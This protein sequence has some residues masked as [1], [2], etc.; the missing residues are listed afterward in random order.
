VKYFLGAFVKGSLVLS[1]LLTGLCFY[2]SAA[3][4]ARGHVNVATIQGSINPAS[5][6]YLQRVIEES[7]ND[8]ARA[9]VIQLDTPGGLVSSTKDILQAILNAKVPV[10]VFVSP[11][12]AWAG[13][14]GTFITIAGHVA[15]MTPGS[16]IGAAHPV[17]LGGGGTAPP[18]EQGD[19]EDPVAA[20][21]DL[22]AEKAE[23]LLAAFIASI[24]Q[25]RNR[26]VEWAEKAV[27]ESVAVGSEEALELGVIDLMADDLN[28]LLEK[29]DG[30]EVV[31]DGE[32][33]VLDLASVELVMLEMTRMNRLMNVLASPDVAMIL[34]MVGL[35]GL[36]IEANS[37][38]VGVPGAVGLVCLF[39]G[40]IALQI[41]PFSWMGLVLLLAGIGFFIAEIFVTSFGVLFA[42]GVV[43]FLAGGSMLFSIPEESDLT[44]NF[45]QVLVP[46]VAAVSLFGFVV[47]ASIGKTFATPQIA[48]VE[49]MLGM[50]ALAVT[51]LNPDG[52]VFVHGEN[53]MARASDGPIE[54]GES[55]EITAMD[56]LLLTVRKALPEPA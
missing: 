54:A 17:G 7:E 13:S 9:V 44:V 40:G 38:G 32:T 22:A 16:S 46:A 41:L 39:M 31:V 55:V 26:N 11:R 50:R 52:T 29:I 36:Y 43:C 25:E 33:V 6:A 47:V 42:L 48:G 35:L 20:Q 5:S 37:P 51:V 34:I 49:E 19:E 1:L 28:D 15:A 14:A 30:R 10:I 18:A 45:W 4:A 27:R 53:W 8:G 23:N 2:S 21:R 56:G 3:L 12:G 24:A